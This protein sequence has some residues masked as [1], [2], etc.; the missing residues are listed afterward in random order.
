MSKLGVTM[1]ILNQPITAFP[2]MAK[3]AE[4]AGFGSVWDYEFYRNPFVMHGQT[5]QATSRI[6]LATG[7]AITCNRTP[8]EFA[9]AAADV[10]EAS[11]GRLLLGLGIGAAG[12]ADVFSG[13]PVDHPATRLREYVHAVRLCWEHLDT[14]KPVDYQ[15]TYYGFSN[16]PFN[17]F[18]LRPMLR[19]DIPIYLAALRPTM[20]KLAGEIADGVIG[21]MMSPRYLD[22]VVWPNLKA[23]AQRAGRDPSTL[24]V[25]SETICSVSTDRAEAYRRARI[26]VGIY[27]AHPVSAPLVDQLGLRDERLAVLDALM[28]EGPGC[29]QRVVSDELVDA[30]SIAGTPDECRRKLAEFT[31]RL[32]QVILHTPYVPPLAREESADA[33]AN[34][35]ETFGR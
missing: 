22:E 2:G 18:G 15:G 13:N 24:D 20:L 28:K 17:P 32:P 23:G 6:T 3:A 8:F 35:V 26:Q 4:D 14:G 11:G 21:Y 19:R 16:P 5:A 12:F 25:A 10:D 33:F 30:L 27:A 7:L 34:I 31:D 9:N 1:P 29:L